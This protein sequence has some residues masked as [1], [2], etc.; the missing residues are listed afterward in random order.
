MNFFRSE[1]HLRRWEGFSPDKE[2]GIIALGSLM[3][4]FTGP[5]FQGRRDPDY[6]SHYGDYMAGMMKKLDNLGQAG[7]FWKLKPLEKAAFTLGRKLKI[8]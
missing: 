7:D 1:E 6:F 2:G 3:W 4:L 5:Y 8:L